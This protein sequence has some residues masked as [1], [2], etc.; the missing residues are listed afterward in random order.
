MKAAAA[1]DAL[2]SAGPSANETYTITELAEEFSVT[3]RTIRFYEDKDLLQ[4]QRNGLNRV[5]AR[6]DRA[7]LKLILRGKRLG[8]SLADIKEML[9]LYDLGDGQIEQMRLTY[10]KIATRIEALEAQRADLDAAISELRDSQRHI[11]QA[12]NGKGVADVDA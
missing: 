12:L 5:Y 4:P 1:S 7:R 8:F 9:D 2:P 11:E 10:R 3:P 6:R